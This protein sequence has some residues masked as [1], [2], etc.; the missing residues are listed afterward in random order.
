MT[1][2]ILQGQE[3]IKK[4]RSSL[5]AR[6]IRYASGPKQ[7]FSR[8]LRRLGFLAMPE[9]GDYIKSWDVDNSI[10]FIENNARKSDPI[11][12]LGCYASELIVAL[13]ELGYSNLTGVDINPDVK[14]MPYRNKV[15]YEV[16]DFFHTG[17]R[18]DSFKIITSISVIEHGFNSEFL[19]K[20]ISR[21]LMP[22]GFFVAS[23]DYWP[24]KIDTAGMEMF[25]MDWI[26]FS[27]ADVLKFLADAADYGLKTIGK[28]ELDA[29]EKPIAFAGKEYTFAWMVLKKEA[30]Q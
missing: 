20:E 13:H 5:S 1:I 2:S 18:D 16:I 27:K 14:Q 15:R 10:R 9:I 24:D 8:F 7:L 19:L 11:L 28:M 26:I 6:G 22:N 12:D 29:K 17:F 23:F 30:E 25:G 21:L 3:E 4:A